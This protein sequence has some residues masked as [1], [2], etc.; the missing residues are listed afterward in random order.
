MLGP[1]SPSIWTDGLI[2]A[3]NRSFQRNRCSE[4]ALELQRA[5]DG[6][7]QVRFQAVVEASLEALMWNPTTG[8]Q[9]GRDH[10]RY[11]SDLTDAEWD[12][13]ASFM[14]SPSKTGRP[15]RWAMREIMSAIFY[16]LRAGC[17]WRMLPKDFPPMT[18]VYGWFLRF[19]REG[20]ARQSG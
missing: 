20:A 15:R 3:P 10:P 18:T 19:R 14:P 2:R 12:L 13:M 6:R 11:G 1:V 9:H 17:A 16:V 7:A 8:R 4:A 5:Q